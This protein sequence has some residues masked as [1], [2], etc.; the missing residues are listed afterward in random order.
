MHGRDIRHNIILAENLLYRDPQPDGALLSLDWAKAYDRVSY[1]YLASVLKAYGFKRGLIQKMKATMYGFTLTLSSPDNSQPSF[2]RSRGVGQGC[3]CAPLVFTLAINPLAAALKAH[4]T[5]IRV[6]D[7]PVRY[8]K[9]ALCADDT[10]ILTSTDEDSRVVQDLLNQYMAASGASLNWDKSKAIMLGAWKQKESPFPCPVLAQDEL[11]RYLGIYLSA[12]K[13]PANPWNAKLPKITARLQLWEKMGLSLF[14]RANVAATLIAS[15]ARYHA[16]C[17]VASEEAIKQLHTMLR[18]FVWSGKVDKLGIRFATADTASVP[19]RYGGLGLP[20]IHAIQDAHHLGFWAQAMRSI[21]DWAWAL[22]HDAA[23]ALRAAGLSHPLQRLDKRISL[24][25]DSLGAVIIT[26]LR[27]RLGSHFRIRDVDVLGLPPH[28]KRILFAT[29]PQFK[30]KDPSEPR[31]Y[32]PLEPRLNKLREPLEDRDLTLIRSQSHFIQCDTFLD[33]D[34]LGLNEPQAGNQHEQH[35]HQQDSDDDVLDDVLHDS[36]A[37]RREQDR[38]QQQ[39]QPQEQPQEEQEE[40][41]SGDIFIARSVV[42]PPDEPSLFVFGRLRKAW[43]WAL[44]PS[45]LP[46]LPFSQCVVRH[47]TL[48]LMLDSSQCNLARVMNHPA[49]ALQSGVPHCFKTSHHC[50][51]RLHCDHVQVGAHH[52]RLSCCCSRVDNRHHCG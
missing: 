33:G 22:R 8:A 21:E 17:A 51:N 45:P 15:C 28:H 19:R 52:D 20:N 2:P 10:L 43:S 24:P 29:A 23:A 18:N 34:P 36:Q 48:S 44:L 25:G 27:T 16:S 13:R 50:D 35:D 47:S 41:D 26:T 42:A 39:Q 32:P 4:L 46:Q 9:V 6:S 40:P 37:F 12:A 49:T 38:Q 31:D 30:P 7:H 14:S 5:G 3:P 1:A 11:L